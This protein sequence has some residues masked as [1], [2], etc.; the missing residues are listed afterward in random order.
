MRISRY[1]LKAVFVIMAIGLVIYECIDWQ[2]RSKSQ[3]A[4]MPFKAG[5]YDVAS[6]V[7]NG[8]TIQPLLTDTLRWQNIAFD[9]GVSGSIATGD[10]AFNKWYHRAYFRYKVDTAKHSFTM[11]RRGMDTVPIVAMHYQFLDDNNILFYGRRKQDSVSFLLRRTS[12]NFQLAEKQ[13]H[14]LSEANR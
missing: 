13:F 3:M 2:N 4:N 14:W 10:T 6:Y 12:H 1:A 7:I 11:F 8:D 5:I 9:N